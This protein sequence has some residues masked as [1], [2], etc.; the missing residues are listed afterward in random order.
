MLRASIKKI[1]FTF[2]PD[3]FYFIKRK[4]FEKYVLPK[5]FINHLKRLSKNDI[6]IDLGAN[7]GVVSESIARRGARVIAFEPNSKAFEK[8][9][10]VANKYPNIE[11]YKL[12]AGTIN[13]KSKLYH[14]KKTSSI[15]EDLT[16]ASS[17]LYNK[18]N[19]SNKIFEEKKEVNFSEFLQS[20][21]LYVEFIKIDIE[22]YEITLINHMLDNNVLNK[23][24]KIYLE[25][26]ERKF[27][28]LIKPTAD[29][30]A[31]IKMEGYQEKFF[32]E[33]H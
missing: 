24:G 11:A 29:L 28:D 13:Q 19:I 30:K 5:Q 7:I 10:I 25:T 14:H 15:N 18:P 33:W 12:A 26:H 23:V 1:V 27:D 32:Y 6:V 17:L 21:N 22:G 31:R 4:Y 9:Q 3:L 2:F 20:L 16:Q 8:L